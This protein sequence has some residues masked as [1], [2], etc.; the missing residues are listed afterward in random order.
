[1]AALAGDEDKDSELAE[2]LAQMTASHPSAASWLALGHAR[3]DA[4][5]NAGAEEAATRA[6]EMNPYHGG[7]MMLRAHV[8][9]ASQQR[10]KA[11]EELRRYLQMMP[12]GPHAQEARALL[13]SF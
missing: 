2:T 8:F 5:D 10:E 12:D 3:L 1:M 13:S 9:L 6:L 11:A 4:G 7:A